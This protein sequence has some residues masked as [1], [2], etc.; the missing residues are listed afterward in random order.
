M[1]QVG[2]G[3]TPCKGALKIHYACPLRSL[4]NI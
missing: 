3:I 1:L 2:E 4:C